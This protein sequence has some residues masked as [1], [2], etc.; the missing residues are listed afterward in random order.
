M[1]RYIILLM[2]VLIPCAFALKTGVIVDV[3]GDVY[4]GCVDISKGDSAYDVLNKFDDQNVDVE[5]TINGVVTRMPYLA[6][7]NGVGAKT[8][9]DKFYGWFFWIKGDN[10]FDVPPNYAGLGDYKISQSNEIIATN[11]AYER[12]DSSWNLLESAEKPGFVSY[13]SLCEKLKIKDVE[14]EV[15]GKRESGIV[16]IKPGSKLEIEAELENLYTNT[17]D[18]D[19]EDVYFEAIIDD[20]DIELE[21]DERDISSLKKFLINY[22]TLI[23]E[24][25]ENSLIYMDPC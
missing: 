22:F 4:K 20:L 2:L 24:P 5:M 10:Q 17:E 12:Y 11:F 6:S 7:V 18:I 23:I 14:F 3:Q 8:V 13:E 15:N 21:S 1:K 9:G 25:I 16:D 19:L